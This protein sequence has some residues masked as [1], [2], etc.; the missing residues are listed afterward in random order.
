MGKDRPKKVN[1]EFVRIK[2]SQEKKISIRHRYP[3]LLNMNSC[4]FLLSLTV[5]EILRKKY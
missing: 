5:E 4:D 3:W 2:F 1:L